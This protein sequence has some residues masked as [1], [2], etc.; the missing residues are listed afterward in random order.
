MKAKHRKRKQENAAAAGFLTQKLK[1]VVSFS[2]LITA[3]AGASSS[4]ARAPSAYTTCE[5]GTEARAVNGWPPNW[6]QNVS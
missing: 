5:V 1:I 6:V 3:C 2:Q 4:A